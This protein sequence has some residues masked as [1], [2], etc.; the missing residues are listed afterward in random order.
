M[1]SPVGAR[2]RQSPGFT[3]VELVVVVAIL[4][5]LAAL[6]LPAVQKARTS[7]QRMHCAGNLRQIGL[8]ANLYHNTHDSF[9]AGVHT[10]YDQFLSSWLTD[11]L[12]YIEQDPLWQTTRAAYSQS[13]LPFNNPPHLGLATPMPL[14]ACPADGRAGQVGF[15]ARDR[16]DVAF[17]SYLGVEGKDLNTCDGVLFPDSYIRIEDITRGTT[18][19][20]FAGE[21]P[22]STDLQ[23]GWWYAGVG[24]VYT[25]SGDMILGVEEVNVLPLAF[26]YC[27]PGPYQFG[28]GSLTNQCDMFHFW[29][30]HPGG[31]N[32]LF[33]D[34][35]VQFLTYD[36]APLLPAL[37]ARDGDSTVNLPD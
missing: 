16:I 29:S 10:D 2:G 20:L 18:Q 33:A 19:T 31:A 3:L 17:T 9:P 1:C 24:Q 14:Y 13:Y 6:I 37:A 21:R 22:P 4:G 11:L 30:L 35:R 27:L 7:Q 25:G 12:P 23:Y 28:P 8:A 5:A 36:A 26:A 32:F 15:A 34:C